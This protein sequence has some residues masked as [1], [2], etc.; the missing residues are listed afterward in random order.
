MFKIE[1]TALIM[2]H[3]VT[4]TAIGE[5]A[6]EQIHINIHLVGVVGDIST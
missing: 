2:F 5:S 3:V 6:E 4:D 1:G